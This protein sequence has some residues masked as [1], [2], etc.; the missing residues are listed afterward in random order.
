MD[1]FADTKDNIRGVAVETFTI[2]VRREYGV[3]QE[4]ER[5]DRLNELMSPKRKGDMSVRGFWQQLKRL[6]YA[7]QHNIVMPEEV[8]FTHILRALSLPHPQRHLVLAHF[9]NTQATR[10]L[11][12]LQ[13]PT[14]KLL[15]ESY[16]APAGS[17][18]LSCD[19]NEYGDEEF[20]CGESETMFAKAQP[21][22]KTR[23]GAEDS[24]FKRSTNVLS[25]P[26][27]PNIPRS[28]TGIQNNMPATN[29]SAPSTEVAPMRTRTT[30]ASDA[31]P[32]AISGNRALARLDLILCPK[33]NL[34]RCLR[35]CK[36]C[37]V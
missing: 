7:K 29:P 5:M 34:E 8:M 25:I 36:W 31:D 4:A 11:G 14:L 30:D 3:I 27:G 19:D 16:H 23:L 37:L 24:A 35:L 18:F 32:V 26:N 12:N 17:A 15:N 20:P 33:L 9:E 13:N 2:R 10:S 28:L 6:L 21:K 22:R 1:F